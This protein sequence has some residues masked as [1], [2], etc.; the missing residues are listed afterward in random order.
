MNKSTP[1]LISVIIPTFNS[2]KNIQGCLKSILSQTNKNFELI[3]V[4]GGSTDQTIQKIRVCV[5]HDTKI[6]QISEADQGIYDAMNKG[7]NKANG[8]WILFL[9][10]DDR[11]YQEEVFEQVIKETEQNEQIDIFYGNVYSLRFN[12]L[13]DG[14]FTKEKLLIKNICHQAIF[15]KKSVFQQIGNFNLKYKVL[16]DWDHNLRWFYSKKVLNRYIDITVAEYADGGF[17]SLNTDVVFYND[18]PLKEY[19]YLSQD[20]KF[21]DKLR[22]I[23]KYSL[24]AFKIGQRKIG[25][26]YLLIIYKMF[27]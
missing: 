10:S 26:K 15:F 19:I 14:P 17:S 16:S 5:P 9:G 2:E 6:Q 23:K 13:Y 3:I 25:I 4:D 1:N 7:I 18:K 21:I 8:K 27:F 20:L 12:G 24:E 11:I 22:H